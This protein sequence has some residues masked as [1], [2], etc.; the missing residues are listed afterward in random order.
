MRALAVLDEGGKEEARQL[1]REPRTASGAA[2]LAP[3][4]AAQITR[5]GPCVTDD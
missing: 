4:L 1:A 3:R 5:L 2:G